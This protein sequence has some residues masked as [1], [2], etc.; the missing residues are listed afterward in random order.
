MDAGSLVAGSHYLENPEEPI[1]NQP[2]LISAGYDQCIK[3]WDIARGEARENFVHKDSQINVTNISRNGLYLA[4]AGWQHMRVYH[5]GVSP[6]TLVTSCDTM[7]KNVTVI[8]FDRRCRWF[9]TAGED[10]FVKLWEFHSSLNCRRCFQVKSAVNCVITHPD[11]MILIISDISGALYFW[12]IRS[13]VSDIFANLDLDIFEHVTYVDINR[14]GDTLVGVTNKGKVIVWSVSAS[15]ELG[16]ASSTGLTLQQK[17]KTIAHS[18]YALKCHYSPDYKYF[19]TT[20]ADGYVHLWDATNVTKLVKSLFVASDLTKSVHLEKMESRWVW[21]CAFTSDS[22]YLF[23]AS[24]CQL[25]LWNLE[26][27]EIVRQY[28]GHSKMISCF[29]FREG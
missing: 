29:A 28:Q 19:A 11:C 6:P 1:A 5:L 13:D 12:D 17:S 16:S 8:G 10:G 14:I 21:D 2:L 4:I 27:E 18:K 9:Y 23:T 22:K 20:G 25:R 26:T 24:G 7:Y 3:F 15:F